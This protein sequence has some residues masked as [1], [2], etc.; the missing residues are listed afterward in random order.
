MFDVISAV[1]IKSVYGVELNKGKNN[2]SLDGFTGSLREVFNAFNSD[3]EL[4]HLI[5]N[6]SPISEKFHLGLK[7]NEFVVVDTCGNVYEI[8]S[9]MAKTCGDKLV[10]WY[11]VYKKKPFNVQKDYDSDYVRMKVTLLRRIITVS[12]LVAYCF[13]E[14]CGGDVTGKYDAHHINMDSTNNDVSNLIFLDKKTH[15]RLHKAFNRMTEEEKHNE[16]S[17][18]IAS[19]TYDSKIMKINAII[20]IYGCR[21]W[22]KW[23]ISWI[24]E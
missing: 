3:L 22:I 12:R 6:G 16:I 8:R 9:Y 1:K 20:R 4:Y 11:K 21:R 23:K 2:T 13:P 5:T 10:N 24:W 14:Y 19:C 7:P 15:K 17:D 18:L